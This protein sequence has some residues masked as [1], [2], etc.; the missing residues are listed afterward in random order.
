M[1]SESSRALAPGG[2]LS[3]LIEGFSPR[4]EQQA[5]AHA[6][7]RAIEAKEV[8]ICEAGTGTG[9]TL[10]YLCAVLSSGCKAIISTGT[11]NLQEQLYRKDLPLAL[12][13]LGV[14]SRVALLKG[15]ANYLCQHRLAV[16]RA[17]PSLDPRE[18]DDLTRIVEWTS[19]TQTGD[20]GECADVPEIAPVWPKVTSTVENCLGADCH[21]FE[22][23]HVLTARRRA[24]ESDIVVVNHHLFFAD[25]A[26]RE[27]GFG[28]LLPGVDVVVFDE[29]HQLPEVAT[30]FFGVSLS[31]TQLRELC[32]DT[33]AAGL[34]EAADYPEVP[35]A[36]RVV[37]LSVSDFRASFRG[38]KGRVAWPEVAEVK[39]VADALDRLVLSLAQLAEALSVVSERGKALEGCQRRCSGL[40]NRLQEL[41]MSDNQGFVQWLELNARGF[42]WYSS[43]L[44][45]ADLFAARVDASEC[46]WVFTSAT[47][48]VK[49][50][51]AHFAERLGLADYESRIWDSP[52]DYRHQSLC[53]IPEG[54]PEP[55]ET[56][57]G[58]RMLEAS[59]PV[60][61]AS[62]GRA[63]LLFTSHAALTLA[64]EY[65]RTH[66]DFPLFV[67]GTAPRDELL[68]QFRDSSNPVLLG[69]SSFWEGVDVRGEA[70]SCVIIDKLPFA[71]PD[72]PLLQARLNA[73]REQGKDPFMSYQL[74]QAVIALKQ[75]AGRL[76]RDEGDCGVLMLCDTRLFSKSY[77]RVFFHSLPDM[78]VTRSLRE[79]NDFLDTI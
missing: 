9:K 58:Q 54:L 51:V 78:P 34:T 67:Q 33:S 12:D 30:R 59:V 71:A 22:E 69:T 44:E 5:M 77:G 36:I 38:R 10:A 37:E 8:L 28:E 13:A 23:C 11:K 17:Q 26:L 76:I 4:A 49:D 20:I 74:P 24:I 73:I 79:V 6:V 19:W 25:M 39:Q 62:R 66:I 32:R 55:R 63:F 45:I 68:R 53:Y 47:L 56:D 29:A 18:Q 72:D 70:L 42:V 64:H 65:L 16:N 50:S 57:Y 48:A 35:Q 27:E 21:F 43:P 7:E 52:F 14:G 75:G 41:A 2:A 46:A 60:L 61:K 15:R 1:E 31:A 3:R 40:I